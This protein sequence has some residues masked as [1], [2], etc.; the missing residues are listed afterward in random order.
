[1]SNHFVYI[2]LN[3][4]KESGILR[5]LN[6]SDMSKSTFAARGG[7]S[8]VYEAEHHFPGRPTSCIIAIK[9]LRF[10][11]KEDIIMVCIKQVYEPFS[12]FS[13]LIVI[14]LYILSYIN[15]TCPSYLKKKY[16]YG[17]TFNIRTSLLYLDLLSKSGLGI[18]Y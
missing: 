4:L 15:C 3:V 14:S 13:V 11:M 10:Y 16:Q 6:H 7:F 9:Q 5:W 17:Q 8:N 1:M 18:P 2:S 12:A